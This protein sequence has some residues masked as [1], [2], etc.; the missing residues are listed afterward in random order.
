MKAAADLM[1]HVLRT[2]RQYGKYM[3]LML[4]ALLFLWLVPSELSGRRGKKLALLTLVQMCLIFFVPGIAACRALFGFS[5]TYWE[6]LWTLP[7]LTVIACA[8]AQ[9]CAMRRD[10]PGGG[11]RFWGAVALCL[12]VLALSGTLLP[13]RGDGEKWKYADRSV[14]RVLSCVQEQKARF[15]GSVLLAAP[16]EVLRYARACDG[17]ICLAYGRDMWENDVNTAVADEYTPRQRRLYEAMCRSGEQP[18]EAAAEAAEYGCNVLVLREKLTGG[19]APRWTFL[20]ETGGYVIY[21]SA[22][23]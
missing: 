6:Y 14:E 15:G 22:D 5:E 13:F 3:G 11:V 4:L 17:A 2:E 18:D 20:E 7:T 16:E 8:G 1:E 23:G 9:L 10:A 21:R 12:A 19:G